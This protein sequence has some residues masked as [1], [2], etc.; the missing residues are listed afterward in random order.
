MS[1]LFPER[2][3]LMT[4][5][6][7]VVQNCFLIPVRAGFPGCLDLNTEQRA[8]RVCSMIEGIQKEQGHIDLL[9][10]Q[11]VWSEKASTT[12]CMINAFVCFS[13][14]SRNTVEAKLKDSFPYIT[15]IEGKP[16]IFSKR[17]LESGLLIASQHPIIAND[18]LRFG[19]GSDAVEVVASKGCLA[20]ALKLPD[21]RVVV[22]CDT[23]LDAGSAKDSAEFRFTQLARIMP[24]LSAFKARAA[25]LAGQPVALTLFGGDLNTNG[26]NPEDYQR[27]EEIT[28]V[29][30]LKDAWLGGDCVTC[31]GNGD[32]VQRLDYLFADRPASAT[33]LTEEGGWRAGPELRAKLAEA[34]AKGFK[35]EVETWENVIDMR[36]R[37]EK[38]TDHAGII[39]TFII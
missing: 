32:A 26:F 31:D 21:G 4:D 36:R 22:A 27:L 30:G 12:A 34:R 2:S 23:H 38:V 6:K 18:F 25:E 8:Q 28:A 1:S 37:K 19:S 11:E 13:A 29:A 17:L 16:T 33:S 5:F 20:V 7:V 10:L 9:L 15:A 24:F 14:F 39:A 3:E 35:K